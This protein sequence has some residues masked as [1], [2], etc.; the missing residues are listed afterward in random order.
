MTVKRFSILNLDPSGA[1]EPSTLALDSASPRAETLGFVVT[2]TRGRG[3]L[4]ARGEVWAERR[5][6]LGTVRQTPVPRGYEIIEFRLV[7]N[8]AQAAL[9]RQAGQESVYAFAT[10]VADEVLQGARTMRRAKPKTPAGKTVD[11]EIWKC[12]ACGAKTMSRG[13]DNPGWKGVQMS[14]K[15]P[16]YTYYCGKKACGEE[17]DKAIEVAKVNWGYESTAG[18][19]PEKQ[20]APAEATESKY[21]PPAS[22]PFL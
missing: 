19:Q 16:I 1:W 13:S 4:L 17:R 5:V 11:D 14:P 21:G 7:S 6:P 22:K 2:S 8:E 15:S 9:D 20:P 18:A 12:A 10:V 3:S